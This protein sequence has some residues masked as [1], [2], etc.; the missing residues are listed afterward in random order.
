MKFV[1]APIVAA[2]SMIGAQAYA[3]ETPSNPEAKVYFVNLEDGDSVS[4]PVKVVF[5]LNGMGVA[6]AGTEKDNTGHHHLLLNR[7]PIGQG[8]DG[9]DEFIYNL[10]AD[11]NHIHYGG[12]QTET[13]LELAPGTHTLQ[14]VLGDLNHVPHDPPIYSDVITITVE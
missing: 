13:M 11:E 2:M 9:A 3:G 4:G 8:E 14:L 7:P 6:P 12:G 10:P 5:G 1:I